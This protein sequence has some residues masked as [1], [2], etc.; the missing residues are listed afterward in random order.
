MTGIEQER[1]KAVQILAA[2]DQIETKLD[3]ISTYLLGD[4]HDHID[5]L[6][7]KLD[8]LH[9]DLEELHA[10]DDHVMINNV[11]FDTADEAYLSPSVETNAYHE[12]SLLLSLAVTLAPTDIV[13]EV[14]FSDDDTTYY[15]YM[16]GPF[17]DLRYEDTAGNKLEALVGRVCAPYMKVGAVSSGCDGSNKFAL[18]AKVVLAK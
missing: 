10:Q 14:W 12:F 7:D 5:D 15:K 13:I 3:T 9:D 17:G 1:A 16:N 18:I 6:E 8:T 4:L 11:V 2:V